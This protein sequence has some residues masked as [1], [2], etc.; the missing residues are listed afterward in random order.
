VLFI[1]GFAANAAV[2]NGL[3]EAGMHVLTKPFT[4]QALTSRIKT[5]I[6]DVMPPVDWTHGR[7]YEAGQVMLPPDRTDIASVLR[8]VK[9]KPLARRPSAL[10]DRPCARWLGARQ[11]GTAGSVAFR[12]NSRIV[13]AAICKADIAACLSR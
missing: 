6:A 7:R 10:L 3:L 9:H 2:S 8:S 1:T 13:H 12:S 4:M 11:V 5:I